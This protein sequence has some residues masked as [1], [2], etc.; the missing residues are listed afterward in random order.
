MSDH[1]PFHELLALRLYG[2]LDPSESARLDAHLKVCGACRTFAGELE[3]GLGALALSAPEAAAGADLP[4]GWRAR[5]DAAVRP[6]PRARPLLVFAAGLAAGLCAMALARGAPPLPPGG[7]T[8][9]SA[10]LHL[11]TNAG[12]TDSPLSAAAHPPRAPGH[13]YAALGEYLQGR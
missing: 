10:A 9:P 8:A 7:T 3:H 5:L 13:A 12:R 11:S 4:A 1:A 2:E 6:A